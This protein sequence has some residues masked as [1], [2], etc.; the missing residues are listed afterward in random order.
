MSERRQSWC[1]A[2]PV[3]VLRVRWRCCRRRASPTQPMAGVLSF[4]VPCMRRE[5]LMRM[6][7]K[8]CARHVASSTA[9]QLG[10]LRCPTLKDRAEAHKKVTTG[11]KGALVLES[12]YCHGYSGVLGHSCVIFC[13]THCCVSWQPWRSISSTCS[14]QVLPF[15]STARE[16]RISPPVG[17]ITCLRVR[18]RQA[19]RQRRG[20]RRSATADRTGIADTNFKSASFRSAPCP[21]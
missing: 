12:R 11:L 1:I 16:H 7:W 10:W 9:T 21:A 17:L 5:I 14:K 3:F 2:A 19:R 4:L 20:A 13:S 18:L 6:P 15:Q 8:T